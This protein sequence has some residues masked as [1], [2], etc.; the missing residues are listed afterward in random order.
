[1]KHCLKILL[2]LALVAVGPAACTKEGAAQEEAPEPGPGPEPQEPVTPPEPTPGVYVLPVMETT[3]IH[4]YIVSEDANE[5]IHYRLAYVADKAN[6]IRGRGEEYDS[7]FLLLLDGGDLYQ[8]A[9]VSNLQSG[10]PIYVSMDL[11]DY[12]AV[13]LGNHEF[14]WGIETIVDADATLPD[15]VRSGGQRSNE[16]PI[17]CANLYKDGA[18]AAFTK[19]YIIVEKTAVNDKGARIP[20]RSGIVGFAVNYARSIMTSRFTGEGYTINADYSIANS[21]AASLE[22]AGECDA[23][24]L[25]IHGAAEDAAARL[26]A[27]SPI[28]LVLGGHSHQTASGKTAWGLPYLQ[29]GRYCEHYAYADMRF[30]LD[31]EGNISFGSVQNLK[32]PAV[33]ATKDI[34]IYASQNAEDLAKDILSVSDEAIAAV[35]AQ[36]NDVIGYID[37]GATSFLI[38]GSGDRAAVISNWMC[39]IT[40]RIGEAD[41]A[42]VN[43]GGIRTYFSL[44]GQ[45]KRDI[46]VANVYEMFPFSNTIYVYNITYADLLKVFEYSMTSGG[47]SLFAR[48]TGI[49]CYFSSSGVKSLKKDGTVIYSGGSWTGDWASRS[50]K[51]AVSEY[52][53][54]SQRVDYSTG[55][56]NPLIEWNSSQRLQ[57]NSLVDNEN[58]VRV[59]R[60]EA[61]ASGGRL[62]L[63]TATHFIYEQ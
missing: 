31:E 30:L 5:Y 27:D 37:V 25:L 48:M 35:S 21:I 22:S 51:L 62:A 50:V 59:L 29:G 23:T 18:R 2:L 10:R 19:D 9:S 63:D 47:E 17:V 49:D 4:G 55:I 26:G 54:T 46:T 44:G 7:S 45:A 40:R 8:G 11:M 39:D 41:V 53:A 20:V 38:N 32:T 43:S 36:M 14:D 12:D 24:V 42:F 61:A 1:M 13:A 52:L 57:S 58:A 15:Y 28:D 3:D 34:H 60:A 56:G 6:D 33:D 16:V